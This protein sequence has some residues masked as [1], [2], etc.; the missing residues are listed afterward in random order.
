MTV[1]SH[2]ERTKISNHMSLPELRIIVKYIQIPHLSNLLMSYDIQPYLSS[3][4]ILALIAISVSVMNEIWK[5]SGYGDISHVQV[6]LF[7]SIE[8]FERNV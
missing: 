5:N 6:W 8:A 7:Q 4:V 3:K 2:Y 1:E